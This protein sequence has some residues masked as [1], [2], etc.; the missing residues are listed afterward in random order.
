[1]NAPL[2]PVTVA[3]MLGILFGTHL[4]WS[5][6]VL[7][8]GGGLSLIALLGRQRAHA[9]FLSLLM[10]WVCLGLLR[11]VAWEA[12]PT[13]HLADVLTDEPQQVRLHGLVFDDPAGLFDPEE[14]GPQTCV[15]DLRHV[16]RSDAWQP[17]PG[18]VRAT[19]QAP[20]EP[21]AYGDDVL[22]EGEW[23]RVP[24][25]GN[26]GQYDWRT[27][28]ARQRIQGLLRVKPFDGV[29]VLRRGQ[30][31]R[32]LSAIVALR[33]RWERLIRETFSEQDAGL[34]LS[35]LLGERVALDERLK[36][37]FVETGTVHLLVISGFNV[38]LIAGLLELLL[39]LLGLPW[40]VRLLLSALALG[41]Y[42]VL[43]GVQP[44]VARATL[45][46]W[47][48]L[49]AC[50]LDRV[51]SWPNTLAAAALAILWI[52]P[53]QLFDPGFQLSFG[54]V[55]SLMIFTRRWQ[56]WLESHLSRVH[57]ARVRRYVT[58]SLSATGAVWVGLSPILAWYFH[59][60]SPISTLANLLLAPLMSA[61][62]TSGTALLMLATV[63]GSAMRWGSGVLT[64]L[65]RLTL[66]CVSWC[67]AFPGGYWFVGSPSPLFLAG[68]YG[69]VS[70]SLLR[71]RFGLSPG[72]L[73]LCWMAGVAIWAWSV[74]GARALNSRWLRVDVLDVGH[75]D[76]IL[77]RT[78]RGRTLLVDAGSQEAGRYRV[79]P[80][81]RHEGIGT[82]DAVVL[83]HTDEDHLG[84]AIPLL[85]KIRVKRLLTN[86]VSG[87][88]MS[89]RTV[90]RLAASQRIP[91][92]VL[93]A[94]MTVGGDAGMEIEVLHPPRG[95]VPDVPPQS[96]DNC[97][98]LKLT[99]GTVSV[100]LT[101]D[102][103]EAGL[104]WI[105]RSGGALRSTVLK[106]PHHGSRLGQVGAEFFNA[107]R[108]QVAIL[109]VGRLHR[110][111]APETLQNLRRSGATLYTTRDDGAVSMQ[112]D[113]A[114]LEVRTYKSQGA[115]VVQGKS[116]KEKGKTTR[117]NSKF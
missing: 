61:L 30:G 68:Y 46:A 110:L 42:C 76:S 17:T 27:S 56:A 35:L 90:R 88:T 98:V 32:W 52:N 9:G 96:N 45:M 114:R 15:I 69:L 8:G 115:T 79:V 41:G 95:L 7:L 84:G 94:G 43:T 50:A 108:P 29:V 38:G 1:M 67:H 23:S 57:P 18:R 74:V 16:Q 10:L 112:T 105:L 54:A 24:S 31:R 82:I 40:R 83:T 87:D 99:K 111:P 81:L 65:L 100:L 62:I 13:R 97:V 14:L 2:V 73:F 49:G 39:R 85:Q 51:I 6:L 37:A 33:H 63:I 20:S 107:V 58:I 12:H 64:L 106:V 70:L 11:M 19:F 22:V 48:V 104:P 93:S 103:E 117:Q 26:P 5:L 71:L 109:S 36:D 25:P 53:T 66:W 102:I 60:V 72:R 4:Q 116:K 55:L 59:L 89:A 44:P 28:L 91:E 21:L 113:G 3:F 78:P 75:G 47:I 80:F 101:G 86:G 77:V 92:T 34:L